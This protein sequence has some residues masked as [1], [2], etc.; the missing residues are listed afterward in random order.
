MYPPELGV[1]DGWWRG[2]RVMVSLAVL[3]SAIV[4]G[5]LR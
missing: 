4:G 1:A 3:R 5:I 2:L